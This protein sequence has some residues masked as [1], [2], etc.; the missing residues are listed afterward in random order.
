MKIFGKY[1]MIEWSYDSLDNYKYTTIVRASNGM[2]AGIKL[3]KQHSLPI[4]IHL[5]KEM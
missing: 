1:Y 5:I 4:Y 2:K 3:Q